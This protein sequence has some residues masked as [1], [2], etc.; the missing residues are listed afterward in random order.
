[1]NE[2]DKI[3]LKPILWT[4]FILTIFMSILC[5]YTWI[6][7]PEGQ[8]IPVH[9]GIDGQPDRYGSKVEGLLV[10]PL[11]SIALTGLFYGIPYIEPRRLNLTASRKAYM[12]IALSVQIF[13]AVIYSVMVTAA[14]GKKVEMDQIVPIGLGFLFLIIGNYMGKIRS[15]FFCGI[16]TPWTLSSELSWNKT[17][18]LGGKLFMTLGALV[19]VSPIFSDKSLKTGILLG[20]I[21]GMVV[22]LFAYSYWIWK[23]DP[24][25]QVS[26]RSEK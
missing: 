8:K 5:T 10:M 11:V 12:A 17:H 1:M 6:N 20:G 26:G 24:N 14:L 7:I 3:N 21:I 9:W 22:F 2:T 19:M 13:M 15:N 25:K 23:N 4:G 16:R 18:R